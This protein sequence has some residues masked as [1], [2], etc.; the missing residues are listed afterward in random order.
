MAA[1]ATPWPMRALVEAPQYNF[2][3]AAARHR[4]GD[5]SI[6]HAT[7]SVVVAFAFT[8]TTKRK[9]RVVAA[10]TNKSF[11]YELDG[12]EGHRHVLV[13]AKQQHWLQKLLPMLSSEFDDEVLLI[14]ASV[15]IVKGVTTRRAA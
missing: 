2:T 6:G 3:H 10:A 14:P 8:R 9:Q 1:R 7:F 15:S 5:R 4:V 12:E 11:G 13:V